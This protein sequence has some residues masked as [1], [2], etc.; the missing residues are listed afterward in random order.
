MFLLEHEGK[1]I[2]R[3]YGVRTPR[4]IVVTRED[5]DRLGSLVEEYPVIVKAQFL[6]GGRG[7]AGA[8]KKADDPEELREVAE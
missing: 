2:L 4:G 7:K 6:F 8:V 3:R 1:E 5:L